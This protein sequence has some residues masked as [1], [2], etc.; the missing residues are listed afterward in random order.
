MPPL[1]T[2]SA[3]PRVCQEV[4][5]DAALVRESTPTGTTVQACV[6]HIHVL[7]QPVVCAGLRGCL[8]LWFL[9]RGACIYLERVRARHFKGSLIAFGECECVSNLCCCGVLCCCVSVDLT[10]KHMQ[11][12]MHCAQGNEVGA[13]APSSAEHMGVG[14]FDIS[15][16]TTA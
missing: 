2:D 1:P 10:S 11:V 9:C 14:M 4:P 3:Q 12:M 8:Q 7:Q 16:V 15:A 5:T 13:W 6:L